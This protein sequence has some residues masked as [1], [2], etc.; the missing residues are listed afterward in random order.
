MK[1]DIFTLPGLVVCAVLVA[2]LLAVSLPSNQVRAGEH[3]YSKP[4]LLVDFLG[5]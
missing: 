1:H 3:T 5:K 2:T 4:K